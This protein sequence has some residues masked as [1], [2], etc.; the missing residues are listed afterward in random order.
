VKHYVKPKLELIDLRTEERLA[1]CP[2]IEEGYCTPAQI[3][4]WRNIAIS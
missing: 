1:T 4:E 2:I 3:E